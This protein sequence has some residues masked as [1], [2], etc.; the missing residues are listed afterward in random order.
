MKFTRSVVLS[1]CFAGLAQGQSH[2][3]GPST[4]TPPYLRSHLPGVTVKSILTTGDGTVPKT[5]GGTTRLAGI[6]DGLGVIDGDDLTPAEPGYF[7]LLV[8]HE[9][10]ATQ[11][12]ARAHGDMGAFVSKW[13]IDKTT[14]QVVEGSDLIHSFFDWNEGSGNYVPGLDGSFDRMCSADLPP[15]TARYHSASGKG[16]QEIIY[17]NGEETTGGRAYGHVVTGPDAG[18]S[19]H[20]EHLG[21]AAFENVLLNSFEQEKTVALMMDDAVDGEVYIYVGDKGTTGTEV[22]KAGMVGGKLYALAVVGKPYE[23]ADVIAN[24]VGES[25]TFTLKLIGQPGNYPV[26]GND[27]HDRGTDTITPLDPLQTFESL[28]MGGPEDG[29]WD[30]RPG[31]E[32]TFYFVTKGTS[33]GGLTAVTR[34]WKL[35]FNDI[36]NPAL[37]GTLTKL[38]DGPENRLGS[39][40]NMCFDTVGGQPKLYIQ[41]DLG[42]DARLSKIW[43]YDI[44]TG[45]LEEI[46]DHDG[47]KFYNGGS[48]FL[49]TNE[50]ASGIVSL[51][52]VLGEGWFASS[53]QV[54]VATGLPSPT[55]LVEHGQLVLLNIANRDSDLMRERVVASGDNWNFRV[56]GVDPGATWK[57]LGFAIDASWN[58][59]TAG[60]AI[61]ASPTPIGYGEAAGVLAT[62]V[63]QPPTPR[64]AASYFRKEFDIANP[65]DVL[66]L[67]LYMRYDDGAVIYV[68]GTEVARANMNR[69]TAVTNTTFGTV[70]DPA[71]R[72][73]KRISIPKE[74]LNLQPSGNVIAVS[75]HQENNSSSDLRM[76]LELFAWKKSPDA[77]TAPTT[78]AGLAVSTPTD[79]TLNVAW[80]AQAGV[81]F[82]RLERKL[83]T[84]LTWQVVAD[85]IPG[86]FTGITDTGLVSGGA[87]SYRLWAVNQYG[88]SATT[89]PANGT[90]TST[91]LP[92]IF[93]EDFSSTPNSSQTGLFT[94]TAGVKTVSVSANRNWYVAGPFGALGKV[95]NGN[96]FGSAPAGTPSDDWLLLP[97]IN[98]HFTTGE[99]LSF[100]TDARFGDT[101]LTTPPSG[102]PTANTGLDVLVSTNYNPAV[103]TDPGTATWSLLNPQATF[104][105]DFAAFGSGV[106]S[107]NVDI[108]SYAG[109]AVTVAF[110][111][112]SSGSVS[113]AAR[114]WEITDLQVAGESKLDIEAGLAPLVPYNSASSLNWAVANMAGRN[115]AR[116]N[117]FGADV[118]A[119]DWLITPSFATVFD[120]MAL[121]FDYHERFADTGS[122]PQGKPLAVLVSTNYVDGTDPATATWTDITPTGLDGSVNNAWR[123]VANIPLGLTGTNWN[124]HIAFRY[125][126]SG[127]GSNGAKQVGVDNISIKQGGGALA[128]DFTFAQT[129]AEASFTPTVTGGV[130]P[131]TYSWTFG[132]ATPVSTSQSPK[133]IY[134]NGATYSAT[135]TVTDG[136][137]GAVNVSKNVPVNFGQF[138]IPAQ[139]G[140]IRVATFN[141]AMNSDDINGNAGDANA[142][143][144]ALASGTHPSIKKVAEVIQRVRPDI[145]L[146]NEIDLVYSGQNFDAAGTLAR[147]NLLRTNYLGVPQV[148]GLTSVQYPY[149]F[150]GGTNTGLKAGYDLRNDGVTDTTPGDQGYGDDS[151]GFGQF[152]GKYG[153][154]VLSKYPIDAA[155]ARTFQKF[156]W[157]D[158]PGALLPEDPA[159]TD[160]NGNTASF[161]NA[162]EL[163][164]FRLSSKSHWD[165]PVI[166]RGQPLHLLCSH[167]T[168][169]VFDDGETLTHMVKTGSPATFADWN[170]LRNNDEIRFWADYVNPANDDYIYDDSQITVT[171]ADAAGNELYTGIPSGGLG[172]N[173][174]FV[175]LGDLNADPVDGDS[176]F[177]GSN[178]LLGSAL[179]DTSLTP[180]STGALQQV[181]AS[182]NNE[183]TKTSSFNLRADFAL[184]SAWGFD[185]NQSGVHWPRTDHATVYLL[186]ASDHRSVWLDLDLNLEGQ[187][188][189]LTSYDAWWKS[190][191]YFLPGD[192]NSAQSANPDADSGDNFF[193]FAFA[194]DPNKSDGA[195]SLVEKGPGGLEYVFRRNRGA[196][197]DFGFQISETLANP[198][199][200][201]VEGVDYEVLSSVIDPA[202]FNKQTLRIRLLNPPIGK[203][204]LRQTADE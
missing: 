30:T 116:A 62:D 144:T 157:K 106:P 44:T 180:E 96:G 46:V 89:A 65:A 204:F 38:L 47:S 184:P 169:P 166:V 94:T 11:G 129:G 202:D 111:Y 34:L 190:Y 170:G 82:F 100:V 156:L 18:K 141:T 177:E 67:D 147:V 55:E 41:E 178:A 192:S 99:T 49:T 189:E 57:N 179:V 53:V 139:D 196:N 61:G 74:S 132:D 113:N 77:G 137:S 131:Y 107:G 14:H 109:G 68:N 104:D 121:A 145:V 102:P 182:F 122:I 54:H 135:L 85:E 66:L 174:R 79:T 134:P 22:E 108:S 188:P 12:I 13:K 70:N 127:T 52:D 45:Q 71:E 80:T 158:M 103:H 203:A 173:K 110:R 200:P 201:L 119:N 3:Q 146:L 138:V 152:P 194:G 72:D 4:V 126:S 160:G 28:K 90:T 117:N 15:A 40:D 142:L 172:A 9:L 78:P 7:Y 176:S 153:F 151:F 187:A 197:L 185:L 149:E 60:T 123:S 159:D 143:G 21:F 17:F 181:P 175:I 112:R 33:S 2:V 162:D 75:V 23:E 133:H 16:S 128:A 165:V 148:A 86:S 136:A 115:G 8:N 58:K 105:S 27:V 195:P 59:S 193:E 26:D 140:D 93:F 37:G 39:L 36:T 31:F 124:V 76:D 10:G 19:Y 69:G 73:W 168:P 120:N 163:K 42:D 97:P 5:G 88:A 81:K 35:E 20:L 43:E 101:G 56:D 199:T 50:E 25:E 6:P 198:W 1:A 91:A 84:D 167:P 171:G 154:V 83:S 183:S 95:A 51:R 87:Y 155:N 164:V 64:A 118:A 186:D 150:I 114:H 98:T 161:Y 191:R 24:A 29:A 63:V 32:D 125:Q 130:E 92:V 48:A